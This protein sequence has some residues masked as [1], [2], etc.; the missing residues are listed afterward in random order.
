MASLIDESQAGSRQ[1]EELR[2]GSL[3]EAAP[4]VTR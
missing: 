3:P 4:Q 2:C 1:Y